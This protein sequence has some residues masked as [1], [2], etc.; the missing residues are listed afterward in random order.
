MSIRTSCGQRK[1]DTMRATRLRKASALGAVIAGIVAMANAPAASAAPSTW[2]G[3]WT[4]Q[5]AQ[6]PATL[7]LDRTE[8]DLQG[9]FSVG[10][11][12]CTAQWFEMHRDSDTQRT[13]T[14]L[15]PAGQ[16]CIGNQWSVTLSGATITGSDAQHPGTAL[17]LSRG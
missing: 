14:A 15:V 12:V 6:L 5:G 9:F 10:D 2:H 13:V 16:P 17:F 7:I 11:G 1:E 8:P 3:M 4:S